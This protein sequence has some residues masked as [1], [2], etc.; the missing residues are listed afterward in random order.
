MVVRHREPMKRKQS[1]KVVG[2]MVLTATGSIHL[3]WAARS[4]DDNRQVV[5]IEASGILAELAA[6]IADIA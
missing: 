3:D 2:Q 5:E 4:I 6:K 1:C